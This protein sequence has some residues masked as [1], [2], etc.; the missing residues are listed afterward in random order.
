M[1]VSELL[2]L[3]M[4]TLIVY[5]ENKKQLAALKAVMKAMKVTFEQKPEVY[6][7]HVVDGVKE[8]LKQAKKGE[9]TPY[10]G[11]GIMLN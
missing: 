10:K 7:P 5:P 6:P 3:N 9:L 11:I 4:Y 1:L 2:Y 8:S